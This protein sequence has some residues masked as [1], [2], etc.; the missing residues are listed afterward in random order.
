[1]IEIVPKVDAVVVVGGRASV[2][3]TALVHL[4]QE[5]KIP[6]W[7]VESAEEL[8]G[9]IYMFNKVGITAGTSTPPEDI[10]AVIQALEVGV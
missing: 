3:T 6:V 5:R 4:V 9:D 8:P 1:L 10:A 7:H 2:N